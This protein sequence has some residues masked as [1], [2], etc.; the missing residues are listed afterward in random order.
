MNTS[1]ASKLLKP[2]LTSLSMKP[3]LSHATATVVIH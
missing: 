1:V 3:E 2:V